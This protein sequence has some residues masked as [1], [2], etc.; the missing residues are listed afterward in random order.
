MTARHHLPLS[1]A[2]VARRH[3]VAEQLE[4]AAIE[5]CLFDC[6]NDEDRRFVLDV[7]QGRAARRG[8]RA[9]PYP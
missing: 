9:G 8:A 1:A 5:A 3:Q 7:L 2:W 6:A 4:Q